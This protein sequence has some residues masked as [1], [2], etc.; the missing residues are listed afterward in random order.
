MQST[1]YKPVSPSSSFQ[2]EA[3]EGARAVL[4]PISLDARRAQ[5]G[6]KDVRHWRAVGVVLQMR[7]V[8]QAELPPAGQQEREVSLRVATPVADARS[9]QHH[10]VVEQVPDRF[11]AAL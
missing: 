9:E 5:H 2:T 7:A 11:V 10:G 4:K 6:Q 3:F 1:G 8:A